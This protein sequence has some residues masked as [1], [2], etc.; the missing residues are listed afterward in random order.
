M[1][2]PSFRRL[3]TTLRGP[4]VFGGGMAVSRDG[5]LVAIGNAVWSTAEGRLLHVLPDPSINAVAFDAS[6]NLFT[7]DDDGYV[8]V[9]KDGKEVPSRSRQFS[10]TPL[11]ALAVSSAATTAAV[12]L[13]GDVLL[14]EDQAK[15]RA[16]GIK[17]VSI[18][19]DGTFLVLGDGGAA[20]L[21]PEGRKIASLPGT[22][23]AGAQSG[24]VLLL[25]GA[26]TLELR[27]R[28]GEVR[29]S[30]AVA[31]SIISIAVSNSG[32]EVAVVTA[33]G[34]LTRYALPSLQEIDSY[35]EDR[36]LA[37]AYAPRDEWIAGRT[38]DAVRIWTTARTLPDEPQSAAMQ[39]ELWTR[40]LGFTLGADEVTITRLPWHEVPQAAA[41]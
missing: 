21:S 30:A 4:S 13:E 24:S 1:N 6:G 41:R 36:L 9:W 14:G 20:L 34:T 35:A 22:F 23:S 26:Q 11:V 19:D 18:A 29:K 28:T 7:A 33:G 10:A 37:A 31:R 2:Q 27:T 32:A 39:W 38:L 17:T 12:T 40:R 25:A 5:T 15:P 3:R 16:R 8:R